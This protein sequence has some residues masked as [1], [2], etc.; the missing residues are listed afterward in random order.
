M[1][2][3]LALQVARA[4]P[5]RPPGSTARSSLG[6]LLLTQVPLTIRQMTIRLRSKIKDGTRKSSVR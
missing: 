1:S 2:V 6:A 5:H 3:I 4:R